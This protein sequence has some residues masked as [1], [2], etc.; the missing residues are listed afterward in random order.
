MWCALSNSA[1]NNRHNKTEQ[2]LSKVLRT[3]K[4]D[5]SNSCL[6]ISL[7]SHLQSTLDRAKQ[8]DAGNIIVVNQ[9][10]AALVLE[11]MIPLLKEVVKRYFEDAETI[12]VSLELI[13]FSQH[14]SGCHP[15]LRQIHQNDDGPRHYFRHANH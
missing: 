10:P 12:H 9:R 3:K 14:C 5:S 2:L 13:F 4:S 8:D 15:V 7:L 1:S 6:D 11:K